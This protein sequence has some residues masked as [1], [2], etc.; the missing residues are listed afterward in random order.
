VLKVDGRRAYIRKDRIGTFKRVDGVVF[1]C[2]GV[3]VDTRDSY[4][5][6]ISKTVAYILT[7]L[8]SCKVRETWVTNELIYNFRK[9][10]GFNN[11]W[12]TVYGILMFTLSSLPQEAQIRLK[13]LMEMIEW[14]KNPY[15]RLTLMRNAAEKEFKPSLCD[16]VLS[17]EM[18]SLLLRFT[19]ALDETG[20]ASVDWNLVDKYGGNE[21]FFDF[22]HVLVR[23]LHTP[24]KVGQSIIAT[25]FEEF[26]CGS[27]LF[28]DTFRIEPKFNF[29]PGKIENEKLIIKTETIDHLVSLLEKNNLG[30]ASGSR[31]KPAKHVLGTLLD[32]FNREALVFLEDME[33]AER[34]LSEKEGQEVSLKKPNPFSLLKA[35]ES[36][37]NYDSVLYVGD[38]M[39]DMI[40]VDKARKTGKPFLSV[41]VY[42][43]SGV[44]DIVVDSFLEAGCDM[45]I[46]SVNELP[47]VLETLRR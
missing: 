9:S 19:S 43:F 44:G 16:S 31:K 24:A 34:K 46:P 26:F 40:I 8:T 45:I 30:I 20:V 7:G 41:G 21:S 11:D 38:S 17:E 35:V 33:A 37:G 32:K 47:F 39:E 1:D 28:W 18:M 36:F 42:E 12:D 6:A 22:F 15:E 23:F 10:G 29:K 25:V 4:N 3:L 5:S 27:F 13:T 14:Q 2:D